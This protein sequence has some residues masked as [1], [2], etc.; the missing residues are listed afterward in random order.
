M[1]TYSD[2]GPIG[3]VPFKDPS[4]LGAVAWLSA[5]AESSLRFSNRVQRYS[6]GYQGPSERS[7]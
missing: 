7:R 1:T 6:P 4:A 5:E 3:Y 2:L